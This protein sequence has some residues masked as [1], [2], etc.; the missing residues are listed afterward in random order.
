MIN[1]ENFKKNGYLNIGKV[2]TD[3]EI[4]FLKDLILEKLDY[5]DNNKKFKFSKNLLLENKN[6]FSLL[7]N[8]KIL[9][10]IRALCDN[11]KISFTPHTDIHVNL[12]AG[13]IHR[14]NRASDRV[15]GVGSDWDET[16][17]SFNVFRIA[18]YLTSYEDSKTSLVIFPGTHKNEN[19]YQNFWFRFFNKAV[20]TLR[21]IFPKI[22]VHQYSPFIKKKILK[23]NSGDCIIFDKRVRHAGGKISEKS[24]KISIFFSYGEADNIHTLNDF[25]F[26]KSKDYITNYH[27]D[28]QTLFE[29]N[30]VEYKL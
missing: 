29:I 2:L 26:L 24:N 25:N 6:F 3:E 15:F 16:R 17:Q 5:K 14:D 1:F 23:V 19:L 21:N 10:T 30:N 20:H 22:Q 18:I 11:K 28:L 13:R 9:S 4:N 27:K 12:G 8:P 7:V